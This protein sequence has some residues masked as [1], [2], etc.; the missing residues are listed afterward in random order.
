[1][2]RQ[3]GRLSCVLVTALCLALA[4]VPN[5]AAAPLAGP[6]SATA[7]AAHAESAGQGLGASRW[8]ADAWGWLTDMLA[9]GW[10]RVS[11]SAQPKAA[12][13]VTPGGSVSN[14]D[15]SAGVD[16][17]GRCLSMTSVLKPS[18]P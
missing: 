15:C 6:Q 4:A 11:R 9:G 3:L 14:S 5:S 12:P 8:L 2:I 18:R 13:A 10:E 7:L 17:W 16:P 1:M